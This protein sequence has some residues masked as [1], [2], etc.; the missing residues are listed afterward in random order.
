[1]KP[2]DVLCFS[3]RPGVHDIIQQ[4]PK[5]WRHNPLRGMS[6]RNEKGAQVY[7]SADMDGDMEPHV[8]ARFQRISFDAGLYS[9]SRID[10][11]GCF[12]IEDEIRFG[13]ILR[14]SNVIRN[15]VCLLSISPFISCLEVELHFALAPGYAPPEI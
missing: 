8:F 4:R 7:A 11:N 2:G 10:R 12:A 14:R 6:H 1:M 13:A 3:E 5:L 15:L 9:H